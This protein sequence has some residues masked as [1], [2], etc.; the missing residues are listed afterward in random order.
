MIN[1]ELK[2][3]LNENIERGCIKS[4]LV[5]ILIEN[6][7]DKKKALILYNRYYNYN[8]F[9]YKNLDNIFLKLKGGYKLDDNRVNMYIINNF[10]NNETC[11]KLIKIIRNNNQPSLV[12]SGNSKKFRTSK[13][14][15]MNENDIIV[16]YVN[17]KICKLVGIDNK[18]SEEIQGQYYSISNE[19]KAH[20]DY[21]DACNYEEWNTYM[22]ELGQR[23]L[24][25]MIYLNNVEK[26][27]E[28]EF[29]RLN[30]KLKPQKGTLIIWN[31][32]HKNGSGN[33]DTLHAGLP[34]IS[35]EKFI[36]TKWF[37]TRGTIE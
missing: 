32:L 3:W 19:F 30:I 34:I 12:T 7:I 24:T 29:P 33:E 11:E 4:D 36:I 17:N 15:H 28:T 21:F 18:R 14:C 31:N 16:K 1:K 22:R 26:G 10:I 5:N 2:R 6:N 35:G 20:N 13:T 27:G 25:C 8:K 37:R 23:T 9:F